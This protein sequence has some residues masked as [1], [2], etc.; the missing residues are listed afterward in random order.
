MQ[1]LLVTIP[2]SAAAGSTKVGRVAA[3][4]VAH[5][6]AALLGFLPLVLAS[7]LLTQ[8]RKAEVNGKKDKNMLYYELRNEYIVSNH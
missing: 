7:H 3:G 2:F 5:F 4:Q 6:L 8:V 1:I